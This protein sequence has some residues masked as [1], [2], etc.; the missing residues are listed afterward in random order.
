MLACFQRRNSRQKATS[1]APLPLTDITPP[2]V[3][4]CSSDT[5]GSCG[6]GILCRYL[7]YLIAYDVSPLLDTIFSG[8]LHV[9]SRGNLIR[10]V[11]PFP[12]SGKSL[13]PVRLLNSSALLAL[14][15]S[16][17]FYTLLRSGNCGSNL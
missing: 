2:P 4:P 12:S 9:L 1:R 15:I 8:S 16:S 14:P 3:S 5:L 7:L 10:T 13:A 11:C 6:N 17:F